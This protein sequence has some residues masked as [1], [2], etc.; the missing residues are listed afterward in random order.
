MIK[1]IDDRM[2]SETIYSIFNDR[3]S[4]NI[5]LMF[6]GIEPEKEDSIIEY[7]KKRLS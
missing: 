4:S 6:F 5:N 7:L 2:K 1:R 3:S